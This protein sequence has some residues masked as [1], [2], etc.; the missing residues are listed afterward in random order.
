MRCLLCISLYYRW[1]EFGL[2]Y[3]FLVMFVGYFRVDVDVC[4][5][6]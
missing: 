5:V 1:R 4:S 2:Y 3:D 6:S